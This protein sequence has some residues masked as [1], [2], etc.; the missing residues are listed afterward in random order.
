MGILY[1]CNIHVCRKCQLP[2]VEDNL[3]GSDPDAVFPFPNIP[4]HPPLIH[5]IL[6]IH[7][8]TTRV[9]LYRSVIKGKSR[10]TNA[11]FSVQDLA[12]EYDS[13]WYIG[14]FGDDGWNEV[15]ICCSFLAYDI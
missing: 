8:S 5:A 3:V 14:M 13:K 12:E 15:R 11:F 10:M 9:P 1:C 7:Y 6:H 2:M 4:K